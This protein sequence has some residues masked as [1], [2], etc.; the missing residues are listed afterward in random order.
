MIKSI[1]TATAAV[2]A[3]L[4]TTSFAMATVSS[5]NYSSYNVIGDD[6]TITGPETLYGI[7]G[8]IKMKTS[9]GTMNTWCIDV[10]VYLQDSGNWNEDT[11]HTGL[12][13]TPAGITNTQLGEMGAL[14]QHGDALIAGLAAGTEQNDV[15]A[16]I[17]IAIWTIENE[18]SSTPFTYDPVNANVTS[19]TAEYIY[20][21]THVWKS[22]FDIMTLTSADGLDDNQ[23]QAVLVPEIPSWLMMLIGFAAVGYPAAR[24][25]KASFG[26]RAAA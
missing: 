5:M 15:S 3:T 13:G 4:T 14:V 26:R 12:L 25:R 1:L 2:L 18:N 6:I 16:A 22:N 8:Q 23:T 24:V 21:A 19:L 11:L 10:S 17:Q 7:A 9:K 20:D